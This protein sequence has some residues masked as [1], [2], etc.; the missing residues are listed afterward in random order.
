MDQEP[1]IYMSRFPIWNKF[2]TYQKCCAK[3]CTEVWGELKVILCH[4]RSNFA[5]ACFWSGR[6]HAPNNFFS[7]KICKADKSK[8]KNCRI[9][10]LK[11][12]NIPTRK[13]SIK[14]IYAL[15]TGAGY[16][17]VFNLRV[18]PNCGHMAEI[19]I[20]STS[21]RPSRSRK[22]NPKHNKYSFSKYRT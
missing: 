6:C 13:T 9:I 8:E 12:L 21:T 2:N 1:S 20:C 3:N 17:E 18:R 19:N 16:F 7:Y 15:N 11:I 10:F 14:K 4:A 5:E 22:Q